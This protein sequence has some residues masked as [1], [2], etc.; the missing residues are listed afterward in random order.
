MVIPPVRFAEADLTVI[1]PLLTLSQKIICFDPSAVTATETGSYDRVVAVEI[2]WTDDHG[3]V[4]AACAGEMPKCEITRVV[5]N[6]KV[7]KVFNVKGRTMD[8]I[9]GSLLT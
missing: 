9:W 5:A 7:A 6:V 2:V 8:C 3:G 1:T 4:G